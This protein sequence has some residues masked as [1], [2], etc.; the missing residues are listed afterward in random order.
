MALGRT[1]RAGALVIAAAICAIAGCGLPDARPVLPPPTHPGS[2][3]TAKQ[4]TFKVPESSAATFRGIEL[5]YRMFPVESV[6]ERDLESREELAAAGFRRIASST[7]DDPPSLPLI[8]GPGAGVVVTLDFSRTDIG[9]DPVATFR[10]RDGAQREVDLRRAVRSG[11]DDYKRFA[12]D[13]FVPG[14]VD[15]ATVTEELADP[16]NC[17]MVQLQLFALSYGDTDRFTVYSEA[18]NLG[19][20]DLTFGRQ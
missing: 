12:C 16:E 19:S 1:L 18:L 17:E 8:E 13:E 3:V 10:H 9:A 14:D 4:F 11:T 7:D 6:P 15:I 2:S 5:Y 20:I